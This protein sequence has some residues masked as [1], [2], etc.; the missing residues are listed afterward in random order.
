MIPRRRPQSAVDERR[1]QLLRQAQRLHGQLVAADTHELWPYAQ[2]QGASDECGRLL[3]ALL[4]AGASGEF[5]RY[6]RIR[7]LLDD[8]C[9]QLGFQLRLNRNPDAHNPFVALFSDELEQQY[10]PT[11]WWWR[12]DG[13]DRGEPHK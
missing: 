13:P 11:P 12:F 3:V 10:V 5:A 2:L 8:L 7:S 6:Q 4:Q 9:G 1:E